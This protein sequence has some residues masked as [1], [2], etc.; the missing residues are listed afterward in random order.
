MVDN[1]YVSY[2]DGA[3]P[4]VILYHGTST[5]RLNS[6]QRENC[7]RLSPCGDPKVSLTTDRAVAEYFACNAVFADR[8]DHPGE[9]S[10][11][12]ILA[13]DGDGLDELLYDLEP[14]SDDIWGEGKC[15]WEKEIA[16]WDDIDPLDEVLIG[17][18]P[19]PEEC[20]DNWVSAVRDLEPAAI[21]SG[22]FSR[23]PWVVGNI[24]FNKFN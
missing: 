14:F 16:C 2:S 11:P 5:Y 4:E 6:I 10:Q 21:V 17:T 24:Y 15:D 1:S 9:E 23:V 13:L 19:L 20:L 3:M 18:E 8:H 12:V 22:L 7:L